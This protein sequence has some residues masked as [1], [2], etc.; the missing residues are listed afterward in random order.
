MES[1]ALRRSADLLAVWQE[2]ARTGSWAWNASSGELFWSE[3]HFRIFGFEVAAKAPAVEEALRR[4]HPD[5]RAIWASGFRRAVETRADFAAEGRV[6][7][8]D[9]SIRHVCSRGRPVLDSEGRLVEY[10]GIIIDTT[11]GVQAKDELAASER[12]FRQLAEAIP[13]HV[14]TLRPDGSIGYHNG[15]LAEYTGLAAEQLQREGWAAALHP[16]DVER[17]RAAWRHAWATGAPCEVEQRM[18][19]RDGSYR[20]VLRRAVATRDAHGRILE[21]IGTDTDVEARRAA[22]EAV[23]E[24]RAELAHINRAFTMGELTASIAHEV[25]QPL[26][27]LVAHADACGR[28]LLAPVPNI[29]EAVDALRRISRDAN[30]ASEVIAHIRGLLTRRPSRMT[31]LRIEEIIR[32]VLMLVQREA[33]AKGV[34]IHVAAAPSLPVVVAD[35]VQLE[36]VILNLVLNAIEAMSAVPEPRRLDVRAQATGEGGIL[37]AVRDSGIGMHPRL[38]G[39]VF[40]PFFTT[41]PQGTGMGLAISRSIVELHGGVVRAANN[42]GAGATFE[43]TLPGHQGES[44]GPPAAG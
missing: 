10:L 39:K 15:Q 17:V 37:V 5:D 38:A 43:F 27:A 40:D 22:E 26:A 8:P 36:Q 3:E 29:A 33:G 4:L 12:R 20:R 2:L 1:E 25:N 28:W 30:R 32:D 7:H 21:W 16:E 44:A 13:H 19:A 11:A 34:S 35:R 6:V 23:H 31:E 41:K 24:A 14:W 9:G 18:R 42:E